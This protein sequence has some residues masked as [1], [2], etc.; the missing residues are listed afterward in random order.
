MEDLDQRG[1]LEQTLV[2]CMGE[3][4]R[5]PRIALE[6]KFAGATPGR[7]HWATVY[8]LV[9]AGAGVKRGAI[10]GSSDRLGGEPTSERYGPWDVA[11]TMFSA[12]GID[13]HSNYTDAFGRPYAITEG[14]P[15]AALYQG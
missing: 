6:K 15:I 1:L 5:A 2:V 4:G 12:L 11:A 13:P 14:R 10:L 7:K 8:S 3:F 9:M